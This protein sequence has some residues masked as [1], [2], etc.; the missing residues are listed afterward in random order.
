MDEKLELTRKYNAIPLHHEGIVNTVTDYTEVIR[1][2]YFLCTEGS[3][4]REDLVT[5]RL[6]GQITSKEGTLIQN[7]RVGLGEV[8]AL[9]A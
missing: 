9:P 8:R 3:R 7:V 6:S 1:E 4:I 2:K 5:T